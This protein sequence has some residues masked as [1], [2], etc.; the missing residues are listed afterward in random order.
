MDARIA[1]IEND[2]LMLLQT[3]GGI[4]RSF[5]H[6]SRIGKDTRGLREK[7]G[8]KPLDEAEVWSPNKRAGELNLIEPVTRE[9]QVMSAP[10]DRESQETQRDDLEDDD[11]F[12]ILE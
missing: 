2:N 9:L 6:L 7:R 8:G 10:V 12:S 11:G 4:A 3:L 1:K 5:G